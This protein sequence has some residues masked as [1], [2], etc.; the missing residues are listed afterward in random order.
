MVGM[1]HEL[2]DTQIIYWDKKLHDI[3]SYWVEKWA[4]RQDRF[5][6]LADVQMAGWCAVL[7]FGPHHPRILWEI[8]NQCQE[9]ISLWL[10]GV[11]RRSHRDWPR[12]IST[13]YTS[14]PAM[15]AECRKP[16]HT[17]ER[18]ALRRVGIERLWHALA[19]KGLVGP[20][21]KSQ[22][23]LQ[24]MAA[25]APYKDIPP[26]DSAGARVGARALMNGRRRIRRMAAAMELE[27]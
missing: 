2:S 15:R 8:Q 4:G 7:T 18:T 12:H 22:A 23:V 1:Q 19:S 17:V 3:A 16:R 14:H 11:G 26:E 27:E 25:H 10:Y 5:P 9:T 24:L 20:A 6:L 13:C 21:H